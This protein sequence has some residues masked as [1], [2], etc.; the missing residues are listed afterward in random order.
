MQKITVAAPAKINLSLDVTGRRSD[1]YHLLSSVMQTIDLTDQI[2]V[3]IIPASEGIRLDCSQRNLPL[4]RR[5]TAWTAAEFFLQTA[6]LDMG[7]SIVIDKQIPIAAGLAGGSTDAAAVLYGLNLL[8]PEA[9]MR[10]ALFEIAGRIGADVPFCLLGGTVLCEGIG[11]QLSVLQ[12]FDGLPLL[13]CKPAFSL[14]TAWAYQQMDL[15][16]AGTRPD[17]AA[18]LDALARRDLN[19]LA[20]STA[21]V[22]EMV[23]LQAFPLL[24]EIKSQ[25]SAAGASVVLMSGSGPTVYG[26]FENTGLR[27]SAM[28]SLVRQ[29]PENTLIRSAITVSCGPQPVNLE[30]EPSS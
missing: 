29:V 7:V 21:N 11:E 12:A 25:L 22:L 18:V 13:L 5:N 8:F 10:P 4:D 2:T 1:G 3:E 16:R 14:S 28:R 20:R 23:S 27:D 19:A 24:Q 26:L 15:L 17:Q 6:G 30:E 9:V